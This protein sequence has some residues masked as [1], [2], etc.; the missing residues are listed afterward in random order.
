M[1]LFSVKHLVIPAVLMPLFSA[2]LQA[3]TVLK[4]FDKKA[5]IVL[6][7]SEEEAQELSV[8]D[9][10]RIKGGSDRNP[11]PAK[12][13]KLTVKQ[14]KSVATVK[15][16]GKAKNTQGFA[17]GDTVALVAEDTDRGTKGAEADE[18]SDTRQEEDHKASAHAAPDLL[19][20]I[21]VNPAQQAATSATRIET[22]LV[23]RIDNFKATSDAGG[24]VS[25]TN[26]AK[27]SQAVAEVGFV[28]PIGPVV[29]V[30]L[31]AAYDQ[32]SV[33]STSAVPDVQANTGVTDV[34][35]D[36]KGNFIIAA[37][38]V[39]LQFGHFSVGGQFFYEN[40]VETQTSNP[41]DTTDAKQNQWGM[42]GTLG[43]EAVFGHTTVGLAYR[44]YER[45][46]ATPPAVIVNGSQEFGAGSVGVLLTYQYNVN[47]H[48]ASSDGSTFT[49]NSLDALAYLDIKTAPR[50]KLQIL[51]GY[52]PRTEPGWPIYMS[53]PRNIGSGLRAGTEYQFAVDPTGSLA[54]GLLIDNVGSKL[55]GTSNVTALQPQVRYTKSL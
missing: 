28:V 54:V 55:E 27:A 40:I 47:R 14:G 51:A 1:R 17:V 21:Y 22:A 15:L 52:I 8:G 5:Q 23:Y 25:I 32:L 44:S 37:P 29:R 49:T 42:W 11:R 39:A 30:G 45:R 38:V 48:S 53:F 12:V 34:S 6:G 41:P 31:L 18:A 16:Q 35:I 9:S 33:N 24:G 19:S 46:N 50:A 10:V 36:T 26:T 13:L 20:W 43:A 7:V 3:A 4:I 2:P